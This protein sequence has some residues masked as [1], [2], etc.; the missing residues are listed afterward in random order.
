MTEIEKGVEDTRIQCRRK[1][2]SDKTRYSTRCS[3]TWS[4]G[5]SFAIESRL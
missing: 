4:G 2:G 5:L 1:E 3:W